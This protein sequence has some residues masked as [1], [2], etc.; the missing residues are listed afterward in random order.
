MWKYLNVGNK[1]YIDFIIGNG[2]EILYLFASDWSESAL[3]YRNA[4]K[5]DEVKDDYIKVNKQF[6]IIYDETYAIVGFQQ[7][8]KKRIA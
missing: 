4:Y 3:Y 1:P 5:Y 7:L 8:S 2:K 6:K